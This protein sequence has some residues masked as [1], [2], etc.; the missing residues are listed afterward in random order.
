MNPVASVA[1]EKTL[2]PG[3]GGKKREI[4]GLGRVKSV[5]STGRLVKFVD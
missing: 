2:S 4:N 3:N 1:M 5:K